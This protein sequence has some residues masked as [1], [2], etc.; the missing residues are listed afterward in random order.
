[1]KRKMSNDV[2]RYKWSDRIASFA[3][4][5]CGDVHVI[6]VAITTG[7]VPTKYTSIN[8]FHVVENWNND[9]AL[10]SQCC[11]IKTNKQSVHVVFVDCH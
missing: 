6:A 1:M 5:Q 9:V 3:Y 8:W 10:I 4:V 2:A 11:C 7:C